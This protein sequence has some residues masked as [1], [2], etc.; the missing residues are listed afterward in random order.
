MET[1][2]ERFARL[3]E[4]DD[5]EPS[6]AELALLIAAEEY[7]AL[8]I[9]ETLARFDALA[10]RVR[11]LAQRL[12]VPR[13]EA[14]RIALAEEQGFHGN[15][16][17]YYAP[18]NSFLNVV[19][20][21]RA[22]I[23]ITLSVLYMEVARRCG[24]AAEGI[25]FP[26]HFLVRV[27]EGEDAAVVLD[28][29]HGGRALDDAGCAKLLARI[30]GSRIP[31]HPRLLEPAGWRAIVYRMLANLK[32][33]YM[34]SPPDFARALAAI[35]RMLLVRPD[36]LPDVRDRGLVLYRMENYRHAIRDLERYLA[37]A[38]DDG[39]HAGLREQVAAMRRQ[40]GD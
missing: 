32:N 28:P 12:A 36:S 24:L 25:G 16:D 22:G 14:L 35:D 18:D 20:E 19:L 29:F 40:L 23:P 17:A 15:H 11:R 37:D 2:R 38:E 33:I 1:P 26:G 30:A 34:A 8:S 39:E 3:V 21:R 10:E 5:P 7:P 31:F 27:G 6:L 13:W 9:D 4:R